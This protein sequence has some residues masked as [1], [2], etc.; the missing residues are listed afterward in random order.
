MLTSVEALAV[1]LGAQVPERAALLEAG[2][3]WIAELQRD[4]R[5]TFDVEFAL[6]AADSGEFAG[7]GSGVFREEVVA[8]ELIRAAASGGPQFLFDEAGILILAIPVPRDREVVAVAVAAFQYQA[9]SPESNEAV[10]AR[11][12]QG[13][14]RGST[15]FGPVAWTPQALERLS[16]VW[17]EKR[18][19]ESRAH[20]ARREVE[21]IAENLATTYE[22]I[23]LLHGLTQNLRISSSD[24]ETGQFA[25]RRLAD[26]L[27]AEGLAILLYEVAAP[28]EAT[29]EAR[30][31]RRLFR[32]GACPLDLAQLTA[33][34]NDLG[35]QPGHGPYVANHSLTGAA[36]WPCPAVR[37]MIAVPMVEGQNLLGWIL[38]F[39]HVDDRE[40]NTVEASLMASVAVILGIHSGN[41]ELYRQQAEFL[42]SV[43]RALTSAI[44]AKDPYTCGHSD[45][46]GRIA[47]RL[48]RELDCDAELV[49]T[50]Y[51][52]GLL[53]DIGKIGI[54]ENVLRKSGRLTEAEYEHIKLHPELGFRILADIRQLRNVLPAVLHHHEQWDGKGYPQGLAGEQIPWIARIMAVADAYDAMSSS[55]PYRNGM[56]EEK[57]DQIIREGAG[58]HWDARVVDAY[59]RARDA[60]R[61]IDNN[62]RANL[63]LDV[64]RWADLP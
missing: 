23:A 16:Q 13:V 6:Y 56:P 15:P 62:S 40:F 3:E 24:D 2:A 18:R 22:E 4:L 33:L 51:M 48:A 27:P 57:V 60:I 37:Q 53:H 34:L 45:R 49:R 12:M 19:A 7:E 17:L 47:V 28:G 14:D 9:G 55:R 46:V 38:A 36:N 42:A 35:L 61:E 31:Q 39:N 10:L 54:D 30:T 52:A 64:Q 26:C 29:Y 20:R 25:L 50:I 58:K 44:D 11:I 41:R 5:T 32:E 63:T 43:V 1:P 59:F 8:P 21:K